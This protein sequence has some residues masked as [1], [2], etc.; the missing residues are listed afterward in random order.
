MIAQ[1]LFLRELIE[2]QFVE[3]LALYATLNEEKVVDCLREVI[4]AQIK[5]EKYIS[6]L[7]MTINTKSAHR[8]Q[9]REATQ[10][11]VKMLILR[12]YKIYRTQTKKCITL[13]TV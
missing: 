9:S 13:F 6:L 10:V 12:C 11:V 4:E 7:Q 5:F 2:G 1:G 3:P 8:E